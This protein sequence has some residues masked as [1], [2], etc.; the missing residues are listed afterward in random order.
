MTA[1]TILFRTPDELLVH[2]LAVRS[3]VESARAAGLETTA[4]DLT[5]DALNELEAWLTD[6]ERCEQLTADRA[7]LTDRA[8]ALS[9]ER[10]DGIPF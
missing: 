10:V 5:Q 2:L 4:R 1:E 3:Q 9:T 7:W 6:A 8:H